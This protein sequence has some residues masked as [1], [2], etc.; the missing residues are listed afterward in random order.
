MTHHPQRDL[1]GEKA[2]LEAKAAVQMGADAVNVG[3]AELADGL[4]FL[5]QLGKE[6]GLPLVSTNLRKKG[7]GHPF[8]RWK[9]LTARGTRIAVFGLLN[10]D[11]AR[12]SELGIDVSDPIEAAREAVKELSGEATI[13]CLSNLG[14]EGE[15]KLAAAV[16]GIALI[17]G[18]GTSEL[19]NEPEMVGET[20]L[21]HAG[22]QGKY[23]GLVERTK[24][25]PQAHRLIPLDTTVPAAPEIAEWVAAYKKA[26]RAWRR[27]PDVPPAGRAFDPKLQPWQ[28]SGGGDPPPAK[29][30]PKLPAAP[31]ESSHVG[32][33]TCRS[34]HPEEHRGWRQTPHARAYAA[35]NGNVQDGRCATCHATLLRRQDGATVEADVAC[36]ACHGPG[37]NHAGPGNIVRKVSE[38]ACRS[39]HR[40]FHEKKKFDWKQAYEKVRCDT[41][42]TSLPSPPAARSGGS[43]GASS[44]G[45]SPS[46]PP[47]AAL[48]RP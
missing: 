9:V 45:A 7:G 30:P 14:L 47:P 16:P 29:E 22:E 42:S 23:L 2:R 13:V 25:T 40:G 48:R 21:L 41:R 34:C 39:C 32:S 11:P 17:V 6:T 35:L 10:P 19:L 28:R 37:S 8:P 12:D 24:A 31:G 20:T 38:A 46:P 43:S 33:E 44:R 27:P 5:S 15:R 26:E 1:L 3:R 4:A 36:E 18:G